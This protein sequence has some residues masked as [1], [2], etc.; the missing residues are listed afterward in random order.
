MIAVMGAAGN[1]G[2]K[3]TELLLGQDQP[4]RVL[5]HRRSLEELGR[6]G[7]EVVS[8]DLTD[9]AAL[10]LLLK[11]AEAALVLLPDVVTDPEFTATRSRMSRAI[12]DALGGSGVGH[13]VALSTVAA[14]HPDAVGPAAG[15]RE[16]EQRLSQLRDR[17]VLVLRSPFYMENLLAGIPLIRSQGVNGSA[18][19]GDLELPMIAARDVAR[20]A[21]E[22]LLRRDFSGHG[23]RLLVGPEDVSLRA[24]TRA[25]G[26]RLGL[27]ELPY[28]QFPPAAVRGALAGAG[29]S[30]EAA[31]QLVELQLALNHAGPFDAV[32]RAAD[33]TG[34]TRLEQLL[35]QEV[36]R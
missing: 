18:I 7:A 15:L 13:V 25:L 29:M 12:A 31:S 20:E 2:R 14:G 21:A 27:P 4:V 16:L 35:D 30:E 1:V 17:S 28:V 8:G 24:A 19:D 26:E 33:T 34:P 6:R 10:A 3:V 11:D 9:A 23:V 5:E 22:R 36:T 32:R